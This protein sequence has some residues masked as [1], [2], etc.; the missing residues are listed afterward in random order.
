MKCQESENKLVALLAEEDEREQTI[1]HTLENVMEDERDQGNTITI[2]AKREDVKEEEEVEMEEEEIEVLPNTVQTED[3]GDELVE[4][5]TFHEVE[6][7]VEDYTEE[8]EEEEEEDSQE[9][10]TIIIEREEVG[11]QTVEKIILNE[12]FAYF[13]LQCPLCKE[14]LNN[15]HEFNNHLAEA[16]DKV[17]GSCWDDDR[18][19]KQ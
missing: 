3:E 1:L 7:L 17:S 8:D 19:H 2:L 11:D 4:E 9:E 14:F 18:C 13:T 10:E 5:E 12:H 15:C 16:H 6:M